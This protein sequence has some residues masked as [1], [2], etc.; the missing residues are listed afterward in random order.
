MKTKEELEEVI[1]DTIT[2]YKQI[3]FNSD[4]P[5]VCMACLDQLQKQHIIDQK[6]FDQKLMDDTIRKLT[7]EGLQKNVVMDGDTMIDKR[8]GEVL[9]LEVDSAYW[10]EKILKID[11]YSLY[12]P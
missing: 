4:T 10:K 5:I 8:T 12:G 7:W 3:I 6:V 9:D 11:F 2:R 1:K